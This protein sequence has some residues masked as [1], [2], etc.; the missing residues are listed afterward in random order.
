MD[1]HEG[2]CTLID[3][4]T[5]F[6]AKVKLTLKCLCPLKIQHEKYPCLGFI[7]TINDY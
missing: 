1:I 4:S 7:T 2:Y 6:F 3:K 5:R